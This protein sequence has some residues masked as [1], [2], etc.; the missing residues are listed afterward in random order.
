MKPITAEFAT[1]LRRRDVSPAYLFEMDHPAGMVRAHTGVGELLWSD[2]VWRGAH[3]LGSIS[4]V[5]DSLELRVSQVTYSLAG[6]GERA[7]EIATQNARGRRIRLWL[8]LL[9]PR[10][11]VVPQPLLVR[12]DRVD[13]VVAEQTEEGLYTVS[14]LANSAI[15]A[16][17]APLSLAWTNEEQQTAFPG[18]TGLD[19]IPGL[20]DKQVT[21]AP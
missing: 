9:S 20:V 13:H 12:D 2:N 18:D 21:W 10:Q 15:H 7:V 16:L 17:T 14:V 19:R 1:A 3:L 4:G 5:Q 11:R 8:A 6:V